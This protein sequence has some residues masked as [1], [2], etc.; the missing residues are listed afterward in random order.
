MLSFELVENTASD[1]LQ[2][3]DTI[4]RHLL[5]TVALEKPGLK[6]HIVGKSSTQDTHVKN[7]ACFSNKKRAFKMRWSNAFGVNITCDVLLGLLE[8][9][10]TQINEGAPRIFQHLNIQQLHKLFKN[11]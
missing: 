1:R 11:S 5:A 6:L 10:I 4:K 3:P 8:F 7:V 9:K 2:F